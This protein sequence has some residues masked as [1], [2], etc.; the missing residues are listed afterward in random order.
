MAD[1]FE[2]APPINPFACTKSMSFIPE[3]ST[4]FSMSLIPLHSVFNP[5]LSSKA[6][7]FVGTAWILHLSPVF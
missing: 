6:P 2:I 4:N 1:C 5:L 3:I 7:Y